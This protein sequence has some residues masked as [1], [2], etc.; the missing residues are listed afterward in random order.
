ML[1]LGLLSWLGWRDY[2]FR[3][4]VR[5]A[6]AAGFS[7]EQSPGPAALIRADWHAA[8]RGATWFERVRRRLTPPNGCDLA[9]HQT[10]LLR[11]RP[12]YLWAGGCRNVSAIRRLTGLDGLA[13]PVSDVKDLAPLAGLA[14]LQSLSLYGC[15]GVADLAPLAGLK[16]L[17]GL[18]LYG[19]TGVADLA[20]LAGLAQ[21]RVLDLRFTGVADLAPLA[22]L[23]QLQYLPL[24]GCTRV[25]DLTPL[26]SLAQLQYL[27]LTGC[28]GVADLTPL[29]GLAQL[30][31]LLLDGCTGLSAE[32]VAA[33]RK[34]HPKTRIFGR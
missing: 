24:D 26:A 15:T 31:T 12:T 6:E 5:E 28:R 7:F 18:D 4:A 33:F 27:N 17:H 13:L 22:G 8:F 29:V 19:C 16:Q 32:A 34:S 3:C 20:P 25:A 1:L 2:D 23:A 14:Q 11:L 21:L 10:L 30:Q 9:Q